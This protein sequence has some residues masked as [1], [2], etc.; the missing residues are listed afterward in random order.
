MEAVRCELA[1]R[2]LGPS[3][4]SG[5][6]PVAGGDDVVAALHLESPVER[7]RPPLDRAVNHIAVQLELFAVPLLRLRHHLVDV[8]VELRI[9][10]QGHGEQG[11]QRAAEHN[12]GQDDSDG[13]L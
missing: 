12:D 2:D 1:A 11:A 13:F 7:V 3:K 5:T 9:G 4:V 10:A 6:T 8:L